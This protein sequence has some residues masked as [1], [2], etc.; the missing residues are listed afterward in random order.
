MKGILLLL[1]SLTIIAV[2]IIR[3]RSLRPKPIRGYLDLIKLTE[4]QKRQVEEIRKGF[5]PEVAL[6][7]QALRRKRLELSDLLFAERPDRNAIEAKSM[8]ISTLQRE[9]EK[10]VIDHILQEKEL[11]SPEQKKQF[12]QVIQSEFERGGLGVHGERANT[13]NR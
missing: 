13:K 1:L 6:V 5:L 11:L 2:L 4:D 3:M 8:D 12:L 7:R 9:L 10:K